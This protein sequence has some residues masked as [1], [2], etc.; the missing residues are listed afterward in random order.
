[1]R[2]WNPNAEPITDSV[3]EMQR[4]AG[5]MRQAVDVL[6]GQ[7]EVGEPCEVCG[8]AGADLD[9][10]HAVAWV[11]VLRE[12]RQLLEQMER[13]G[14]AGRQQELAAETAA[15]VVGAY[16]RSLEAAGSELLPG[17]RVVLV[18]AFLGA[19]GGSVDVAGVLPAGEDGKG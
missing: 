13:L 9:S 12:L 19:L 7:L 5:S 10:V 16:R 15:F 8:R 11:R 6:G 2:V 4:L 17:V 1:L 3:S 14:I 18:E